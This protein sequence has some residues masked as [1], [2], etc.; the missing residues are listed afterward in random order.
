MLVCA[1]R[2]R[3]LKLRARDRVTCSVKG[4]IMGVSDDRDSPSDLGE[5]SLPV[6][7]IVFYWWKGPGL[8][9][10]DSNRTKMLARI[11]NF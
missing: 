2:R 1:G 11:L 6:P 8:L 9:V 4:E 7:P 10:F 3:Y 5:C